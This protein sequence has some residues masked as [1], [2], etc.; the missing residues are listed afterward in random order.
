MD[1]QLRIFGVVFPVV[2]FPFFL[3][4][5]GVYGLLSSCFR[6]LWWYLEIDLWLRSLYISGVGVSGSLFVV[7]GVYNVDLE[8]D[9][10]L[11]FLA[12]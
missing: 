9:L 11:R 2:Y 10:R 8:M 6:H 5:F 1:L 7:F 3:I 12:L 4:A